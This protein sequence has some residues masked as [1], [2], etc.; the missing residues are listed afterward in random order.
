M[1]LTLVMAL[2]ADGKIGRNADHFPDW[3]EKAD[4]KLF[5]TLSKQAGVIIMGAKTFDTLG[6]PLPGRKHIVM[7]RSPDRV[8]PW[9]NL[10]YTNAAP[11]HVLGAL[12]AEGHDRAVLAGGG[13]INYLFAKDGLIDEI[14]ITYAPRLFGAGLD[15]FS[16]PVE[17]SLAL[18]DHQR[19]GENTLMAT[20]QVLAA[21]A[22]QA[23]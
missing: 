19:I 10:R 20:Y 13:R 22:P 11:A 15:L 6:R 2:T 17:M 18:T 14:V 4:K 23:E 7:T 1:K 8:S 21:P 16:G 3:T 12:A 9:E 5:M